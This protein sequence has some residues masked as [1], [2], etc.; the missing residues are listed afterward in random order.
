MVG[1]WNIIKYRLTIFQ[2]VTYNNEIANMS[3]SELNE[4]RQYKSKSVFHFSNFTTNVDYI[5]LVDIW[6]SDEDTMLKS[7]VERQGN[8]NWADIATQIPGRNPKQCSERWRHHLA[9]GV[10]KGDWS[11]EEDGIILSTQ[12]QFGNQWSHIT[13]LLVGRTDNDVKN[14][15]H[16]LRRAMTRNHDPDKKIDYQQVTLANLQSLRLQRQSSI[17]TSEEKERPLK[18][19]RSMPTSAR[20]VLPGSTSLLHSTARSLPSTPRDMLPEFCQNSRRISS[21]SCS[22]E[23]IISIGETIDRPIEVSNVTNVRLSVAYD[24][25]SPFML[26]ESKFTGHSVASTAGSIISESS[27]IVDPVEQDILDY[28]ASDIN[29]MAFSDSSHR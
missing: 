24:S 16:S 25:S 4:N 6:S 29:H 7:I 10:K 2:Y 19:P 8:Y 26:S 21:S 27:K 17:N 3:S 22:T 5:L 12:E 11:A 18:S 20:S 9:F 23:P 15:Y 14:R 13:R 28:F 1:N